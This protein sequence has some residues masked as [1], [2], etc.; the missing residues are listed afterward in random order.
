MMPNR[1]TPSA[2]QIAGWA[3][4]AEKLRARARLIAS[5]REAKR[6]AARVVMQ[7]H[8]DEFNAVR[9]ARGLSP[10]DFETSPYFAR[11]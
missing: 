11:T 10:I 1:P 9:L 6:G 3:S 7:K 5:A 8:R 2:A 4:A